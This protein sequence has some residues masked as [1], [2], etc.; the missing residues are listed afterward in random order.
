[1]LRHGSIY[2][3]DNISFLEIGQYRIGIFFFAVLERSLETPLDRRPAFGENRLAFYLEIMT[4]TV[5][6][7]LSIFV[8]VL[9]G[10]GA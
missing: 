8:L 2:G 6:D 1:M 7:K 5:Y 4:F 10:Y 9:A 3:R